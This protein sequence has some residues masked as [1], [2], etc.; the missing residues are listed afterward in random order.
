MSPVEVSLC[1]KYMENVWAS[2]RISKPNYIAHCAQD[3][4]IVACLSAQHGWI[5]AAAHNWKA[6][7]SKAINSETH[8]HRA[9]IYKHLA[10]AQHLWRCECSFVFIMSNNDVVCQLRADRYML[11]ELSI[12]IC[13]PTQQV[14]WGHCKIISVC[15]D[16]FLCG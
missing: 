6:M 4:Y 8:Q 1:V 14:K 5:L 9:Y 12:S 16:M 7:S 15:A 2:I 10:R 3:F 11:Q 13:S